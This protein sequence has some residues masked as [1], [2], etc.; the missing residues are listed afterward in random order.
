MGKYRHITISPFTIQNPVQPSDISQLR[1]PGESKFRS[2]IYYHIR[3]LLNRIV[4][5]LLSCYV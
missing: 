4:L 3:L 5:G 2:A 1:D